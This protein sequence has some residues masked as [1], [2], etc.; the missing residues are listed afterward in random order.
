LAAYRHHRRVSHLEEGTDRA[1]IAG[2]ERPGSPISIGFIG[3]SITGL[4]APEGKAPQV[5]ALD[6][7]ARLDRPIAVVICSKAGT[8]TGEWLPGGPLFDHAADLMSREHVRW[9][10]VMLGTNDAIQNVSAADHAAHI[11]RIAEALN[12]R[13]FV[14]ILNLPPSLHVPTAAQLAQFTQ[15][16]AR[17]MEYR[18]VSAELASSGV[19]AAGDTAALNFFQQRP[20]LYRSDGVHPNDAG[21]AAIG[22]LWQPPL[23]RAISFS[24]SH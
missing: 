16:N 12:K 14:T 23:I 4:A 13:G 6:L 22:H 15:I 7:S 11:R 10:C 9:A 3:D 19:V 20:S 18:D 24:P 21:I 1:W 2:P 8:T 5:C 17:L